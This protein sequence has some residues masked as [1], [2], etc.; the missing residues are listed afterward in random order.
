MWKHDVYIRTRLVSEY[1]LPRDRTRLRVLRSHSLLGFQS[2]VYVSMQE[3]ILP[4][5][6]MKANYGWLIVYNFSSRLENIRVA[7]LSGE[8][9]Q[10]FGLVICSALIWPLSWEGS[11]SCH[12]CYVTW[13]R[14]AR[15]H[16]KDRSIRVASYD[17]PGL[18]KICSS[19]NWS[20]VQVEVI[21]AK[22]KKKQLWTFFEWISKLSP[23]IFFLGNF[24]IIFIHEMVR[25]HPPA[26]LI[27]V[28][29][30]RWTK[31]LNDRF[32]NTMHLF[33]GLI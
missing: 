3:K 23:L 11:L 16:P 21:L 17:K 5:R 15:S 22:K 8:W 29:G 12:C 4:P 18:L 19:L 25:V 27:H 1:H 2:W 14:F 10:N 13:F 26:C 24:S 6:T 9:L 33:I 30:N 7:I 31:T 32:W 28:C 20:A